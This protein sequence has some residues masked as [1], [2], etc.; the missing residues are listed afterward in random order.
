MVDKAL[1]DISEPIERVSY[2]DSCKIYFKNGGWIIARFSRTEP[3][4]H[5]SARCRRHI[6]AVRMCELF[7]ISGI[8]GLTTGILNIRA[9]TVLSSYGR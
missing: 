1:P 3:L 9:C 4:L 5:I 2:M 8:E 7:E 6:Q